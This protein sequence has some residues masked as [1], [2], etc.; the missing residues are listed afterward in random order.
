MN[1]SIRFGKV[2]W[3]L[4]AVV[5]V[6]LWGGIAQAASQYSTGT[7]NWDAA[8]PA[9]GPTGGPYSLTWTS[10]NDAVFEGSAGTVSVDAAGVTA[11]N[12]TFN[13]SGYL[14]SS[15]TLTL[16]GTSP[17]IT[18]SAGFT[19]TINSAILS[20]AGMAVEG[21][22]TLNLGGL[23]TLSGADMVLGTSSS[24]N[25]LNVANGGRLL[26]STNQTLQIGAGT[27]GNNVLNVSTPGTTGTQ[28]IKI[29]PLSMGVSSANNE[30][31]ISNGAY[32]ARNATV[33]GQA[34]WSLG[35]NLGADNN[36]III[37]GSGATADMK[38][39]TLRQFLTV[40]TAGSGNYIKAEN[41]GTLSVYRAQIGSNSGAGGGD[42]N[43]LLI[44]GTGSNL[45]ATDS[46]MIFTLGNS[47]GATGNY[48]EV[49]NGATGTLTNSG[50][51]NRAFLIG[52]G[53]DGQSNG[54]DNNYLKV[55]GAGSALTISHTQPV[56]VGGQVTSNTVVD[57]NTVGNTATGNHIDVYDGGSLTI[58]SSTS[59]YVMGVNSSINMG[60][61]S[62][63]GGTLSV[64]SNGGSFYAG[65]Y[66]KNADGRLN[67]NNGQ[68]TAGTSGALISGSGQVVLNGPAFIQNADTITGNTISVPISGIGSL[69]KQ[70]IGTLMLNGAISY[71]G[72]T[73]VL[74]GTLSLLTYSTSGLWDTA[75]VSLANGTTLNLNYGSYLD[76]V[77]SLIVGG[78]AEPAGIYYG[79]I[80][81]GLNTVYI[82][83]GGSLQVG[84]AVAP[85]SGSATWVSDGLTPST[86]SSWN[87][88]TNWKDGA[89]VNGVPGVGMTHGTA[90]FSDSA[91]VASIDLTGVNPNL[92]ALTFSTSSY[93]LS[94]GSLTLDNGAGT[95]TVTVTGGTQTIGTI[96]STTDLTLASSTNMDVQ[97]SAS[98]LKIVGN[99][100]EIGVRSL[101][102]LGTGTLILSG[103]NSYS[104]G[105][106]VT[107]GTVYQIKRESLP[108]NG[109]LTIGAGATF[110]Y[111]PNCLNAGSIVFLTSSMTI[112]SPLAVSPVPEPSTLALLVAGVVAGLG[113][114]RKRRK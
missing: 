7:F 104:G 32:V 18:T 6:A 96:S 3:V 50:Q 45:I 52:G 1:C 95:A 100:G 112:S 57:S 103:T 40:G 83:G 55:T 30:L 73:S 65:I 102:K 90:T 74:G 71:T 61:G 47:P 69:T 9:W 31:N 75:A 59:L 89:G 70:G 29:G 68:L 19:S 38:Y 66:L 23:A 24:G 33:N 72:S 106:V 86:S 56:S 34:A 84:A 22:G 21:G 113:A 44:T 105:T 27:N 60:D 94:G 82:T 80:T 51:T 93:T 109:S 49:A 39:N 48:L 41:G 110:I 4:L 62:A 5:A 98:R 101:T 114:W 76:T 46:Q 15:S 99:I 64:G 13:T 35:T 63:N 43:Y 14:V 11:H 97:G 36:R 67:F 12:L 10:G 92:K 81:S 8:A 20:T 79:T 42:N 78:V 88:A 17:T 54:S 58:A 37:S 107:A 77:S 108:N 26:Y 25:T 2:L 87:T 85:F 111:D 28:S 91:S 16:N 53:A